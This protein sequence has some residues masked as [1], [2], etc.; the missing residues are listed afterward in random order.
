MHTLTI[1]LK[2]GGYEHELEKRF[3]A[4]NHIHNVCV[5]HMKH[6]MERLEH[7]KKYQ[8]ARASFLSA[9]KEVN[10]LESLEKLCRE[11][12]ESLREQK[13]LVKQLSAFLTNTGNP[14]D[15]PNTVWNPGS[16]CAAD[17]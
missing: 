15:S 8:T 12:R 2:T 7:D 6:L 11:D 5:K 9:R 3:R 17:S 13:A 1:L 14:W 10:R 4:M 16:R